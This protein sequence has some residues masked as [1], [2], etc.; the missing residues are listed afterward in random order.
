[1]R[2]P[3]HHPRPVTAPRCNGG[4]ATLRTTRGVPAPA[5]LPSSGAHPVDRSPTQ[6]VGCAG[7]T[8]GNLRDVYGIGHASV[9]KYQSLGNAFV[10]LVVPE[11]NLRTAAY[12][13]DWAT[14]AREICHP[15]HGI[16]ADGLIVAGMPEAHSD[17]PVV[18]MH[19]RNSDGTNAE[20]S[21][22]GLACLAASLAALSRDGIIDDVGSLIEA[23]DEMSGHRFTVQ[24]GA[25]IQYVNWFEDGARKSYGNQF[26]YRAEVDMQLVADGPPISPALE[27]AIQSDWNEARAATQS[28]GNPHLIVQLPRILTAQETRD[29]GSKYQKFFA[30]G[31]NVQFLVATDSDGSI[32]I[33]I[34]E[35]GA[36]LTQACGS[37]AV[38]AAHQARRWNLVGQRSD[39]AVAMPGGSALV[40][41]PLAGVGQPLEE[42]PS[43][44]YEPLPTPLSPK[45]LTDAHYVASIDWPIEFSGQFFT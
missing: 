43:G 21:G 12:Q 30:D 29:Y 23:N 13:L 3:H 37:G 25:G 17:E 19:L 16:A 39:V 6:A 20:T 9:Y 11:S 32:E 15:I 24:T 41:N 45:L 22:N 1:M 7:S 4:V 31:I 35:R 5:H 33:T 10:I 40:P 28:V 38:V 8:A 26:D 42:L 44:E 27:E 14:V 34:W 36:G 2:S 18:A